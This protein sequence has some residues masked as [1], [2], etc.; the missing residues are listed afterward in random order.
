MSLRIEEDDLSPGF[1]CAQDHP[2]AEGSWLVVARYDVTGQDI[3]GERWTARRV[4]VLGSNG[5]LE[6]VFESQYVHVL[7]DPR[8]AQ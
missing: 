3:H 1:F 7:G 4:I 2:A 6:H 5:R 8:A